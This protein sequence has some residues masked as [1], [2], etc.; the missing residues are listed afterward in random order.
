MIE[1]DRVL[2][3]ELL[4]LAAQHV[5]GPV[6]LAGV[7]EV[8]RGALAGPAS[9]GIVLVS[10]TTSDQF[11]A[12]LRDSKLMSAAAREAIVDDVV[13]WADAAAVGHGQPEAV[14]EFGIIGALRLA[15]A[16]ALAQLADYPIAGVL[17]D[18]SHDWWTSHE[19]PL[20]PQLPALPVHVQT[21]ADA[22]CAVVAAA[23]VLA[24]VARDRRMV[25]LAGHYPGYDWE[26]NK[27]YSSPRHIEGLQTLGASPQHRTSWKLPGLTNGTEGRA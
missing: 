12:G 16:D 26:H 15:A 25:E 8:G 20:G 6:Y 24:K 3:K 23:S 13:T 9:V 19:L 27:G 14:N 4:S 1:P 11:P 2:E 10:K 18:G 7:D 5:S 21:K 17:L 22:T